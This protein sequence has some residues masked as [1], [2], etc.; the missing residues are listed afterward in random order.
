[1]V[2]TYR[3]HAVHTRR[4]MTKNA[5]ILPNRKLIDPDRVGAALFVLSDRHAR[6]CGPWH[7]HRRLQ[8]LHVS[9]GALSVET[10]AARYVIPP[11]RGVWVAPGTR[12]RILSRT[13]FWLTT[14]YIDM[15]HWEMAPIST[16]AVSVDRLSDALLIAVSAFGEAGPDTLAE[17]RMVE[18][19]K[20]R[21]S[22]LSTFDLVLPIPRSDRLRRLTDRL[23]TDPSRSATLAVLAAEAALSER[24]AA[25]LFKS[26][27]GL[28]FGTWR[29]HL[30]VQAALAHLAAGSS[31]TETAYAVGYGDV[32]SFIEAF[33]TV[34]GQTPFQAMKGR[35]D[36]AG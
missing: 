33:R 16:C 22:A 10:D 31:V 36:A 15:D 6:I 35:S 28:S 12:H 17:E 27:T 32:S 14:C 7:S 4:K 9:E 3:R 30:R 34:C 8:L 24:T 21:L 2:W 5:V 18:V 11:Q 25:R 26:E 19:L 13:P 23:M 20:D 1:M 29:L